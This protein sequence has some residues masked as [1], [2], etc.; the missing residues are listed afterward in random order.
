MSAMCEESL[1]SHSDDTVMIDD[2]IKSKAKCTSIRESLCLVV[3][4]V[5]RKSGLVLIMRYRA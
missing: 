2:D 3:H 5:S 1:E 4:N